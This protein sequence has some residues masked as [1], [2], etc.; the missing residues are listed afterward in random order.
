MK[1]ATGKANKD[2]KQLT[3]DRLRKSIYQSDKQIPGIW[4][5]IHNH[6]ELYRNSVISLAYNIT[7]KQ[8]KRDRETERERVGTYEFNKGNL[9][10]FLFKFLLNLKLVFNKI[11]QIN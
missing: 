8:R 4:L 11:H 7:Q 6:T 5:Y 9:K 10:D 1:M 3:V 2:V